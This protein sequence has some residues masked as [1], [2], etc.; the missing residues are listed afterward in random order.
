MDCTVCRSEMRRVGVLPDSSAMT[1]GFE[2]WLYDCPEGHGQRWR[3]AF[4]GPAILRQ[5][6]SRVR[7]WATKT[8]AAA[9]DLRTRVSVALIAVP[10]RL[11]A[12]LLSEF[13]RVGQI[14][15]VHLYAGAKNATRLAHT[16]WRYS[17][18]WLRHGLL[19][20]RRFAGTAMSVSRRV[21]KIVWNSFSAW[22]IA[23]LG[24]A[25]GFAHASLRHSMLW[26]R[27]E[28]LTSASRFAATVAESRRVSKIVWNSLS[29]WAIAREDGH[30]RPLGRANAPRPEPTAGFAHASR[31]GTALRAPYGV[32]VKTAHKSHPALGVM[33]RPAQLPA[34]RR[35][36]GAAVRPSVPQTDE[37]VFLLRRLAKVQRR[38]AL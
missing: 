31:Q 23:R 14:V 12:T 25:N 38:A 28:L 34:N 8:A 18:F 7:V 30:K 4:N 10:R 29:A 33:T 13:G 5:R 21:S 6:P 37:A 3:R 11:A 17:A 2:F 19:T 26:L 15:R 24:R 1:A 35:P 22:A 27:H 9:R 36:G 16:S 32:A 20:S